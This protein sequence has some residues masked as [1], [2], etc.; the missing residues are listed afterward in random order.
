MP[1]RKP[2]IT[3]PSTPGGKPAGLPKP[4]LGTKPKPKRGLPS[5]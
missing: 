4:N 3:I 5:R 1:K 2:K